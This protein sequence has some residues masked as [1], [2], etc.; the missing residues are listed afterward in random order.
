MVSNNEWRKKQIKLEA[1][2]RVVTNN[3]RFGTIVRLE[4]DQLGEYYIVKLDLLPGEFAYDPWDVEKAN[5][6]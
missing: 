1:G 3:S 4:R 6:S 2:D 5:E